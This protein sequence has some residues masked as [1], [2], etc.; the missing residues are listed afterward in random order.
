M[1]ADNIVL[2]LK[3]KVIDGLGTGINGIVLNGHNNITI[4]NGIIKDMVGIGL[5]IQNGT[6]IRLENIDFISNGTGISVNASAEVSITNCRFI[7]N[8]IDALALTLVQDGI[9]NDCLFELNAGAEVCLV[10]SCT[11]ILI[12]S[13]MLDNNISLLTGALFAGLRIIGGSSIRVLH[14]TFCNNKNSTST[15][16]DIA[17]IL[18]STAQN[19]LI[20]SCICNGNNTRGNAFGISVIG[21]ALIN[22]NKTFTNLNASIAANSTGISL[23]TTL[24]SLVSFCNSSQNTALAGIAVG[25]DLGTGTQIISITDCLADSNIGNGTTNSSVGFRNLTSTL[26]NTL[27]RN[28]AQNHGTSSVSGNTN[29]IINGL[30]GI[31]LLNFILGTGFIIGALQSNLNNISIVASAL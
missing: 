29:F 8:T 15:V 6:N 11:N 16:G 27:F 22:I 7:S 5:Q 3:G 20:D 13:I 18:I 26:L 9:I 12:D 14:S 28:Q 2:D 10:S 24:N 21:S 23:D 30:L 19:V 25:F 31:P 17:G 4:K 1:G